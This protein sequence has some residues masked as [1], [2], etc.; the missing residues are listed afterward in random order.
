VEPAGAARVASARARS[1]WRAAVRPLALALF[2]AALYAPALRH[3]FVYDDRILIVEAPGPRGASDVARVFSERHWWNLPYYRPVSRLTMVL[4]K[5]LHGNAPAPFHAFNVALAAAAALALAAVLRHPRLGV[6][7][8]PAWLAA[9]L[10]AAHPIASDCVYP[11]SSGRETLLPTCLSLVALVF[12]LRRG[13][14]ARG[15]ALLAAALALFAKE[16]AVVLPL[17][18]VWA[19]LVGASDDPPGR[20]ARRWALRALPL[21][22]LVAAY[23]GVRARVLGP[24]G[25]GLELAV[26]GAPAGPLLSLLYALQTIFAP[27]GELVYEPRAEVWPSAPRLAIALAAVA[28]LALGAVRA[29][30]ARRAA[31][32]FAGWAGLALLPT[33]NF[34]AQ[35]APFAERYALLA[36]SGVAGVAAAT[37]SGLRAQASRRA[38]VALG[39]ALVL[40]AA[41]ASRARAAAWVDDLA[42]YRQWLA[43]DPEAAQ[44]HVGLGQWFDERGD[45]AES[46]A[47]YEAAIALRPG[48]AVAHASLGAVLLRHGRAAEAVPRLERAAALAPGEATTWSNLGVA[49]TGLGRAGDAEAAFA[50][51]LELDPRLV[52]ARVNLAALLAGRGDAE[53]AAAAYRAALALAPEN[54]AAAIGLA[55]LLATSPDP[56]RRDGREA[57]ALAERA[58]RAADRPGT[59]ALAALAAALAESGRF[60]EAVRWQERALAQAPAARAAEHAARLARY[61]EGRAWRS[62]AGAARERSSA[63]R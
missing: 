54:A 60:D 49:L 12:W 40:A 10:F 9:A 46:V 24:G 30:P 63:E 25:S 22:A 53:R 35:E 29:G 6:A 32:F 62:E 21:A 14:R 4:Q 57:L 13:A 11:I 17:L 18:F 15:L 42:F 45:F 33:A 28:L 31:L 44:P 19:D 59:R 47:H 37:A 52:E 2:V 56:S 50:R 58:V 23:L 43:T 39:A 7:E 41:A 26:Q 5:G 34:F 51:A 48:Y 36:L 55:E 3:G 1:P 61:R 8:G 16:Q 20:S 27:F 38:A